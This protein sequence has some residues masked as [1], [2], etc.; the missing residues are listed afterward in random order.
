MIEVKALKLRLFLEGVEVPVIAADVNIQP[1]Q[2][3]QASIQLIATNS[4]LLFLPRTLVHLFYLD[5]KP[6]A[7]DIDPE[8]GA[9]LS[10]NTGFGR[11]N[12]LSD[13]RY[14]LLFAGEIVGFYYT[15]NSLNRSFVVQC[16]DFSSYWDSCYQWFADYSVNG[17]FADRSHHFVGSN[18]SIFNNVTT[19]VQ[20]GLGNILNSKPENPRYKDL[21]RG[22]LAGYIHLLESI[23]GIRP[24]NSSFTGFRGANDFFS[25]AELRYGLTAMLGAVATDK[26][27]A[28]LYR[29][30]AFQNWLRNGM[31]S[32]GSLV[33]FRDVLR[34]AGQYIFHEVYPNPAAFYKPAG[35]QL[36]TVIVPRSVKESSLGK[37]AN[38]LLSQARTSLTRLR[39]S[40]EQTGSST[41]KDN[42][43]KSTASALKEIISAREL[44][45]SSN[46]NDSQTTVVKLDQTLSNLRVAQV[47][48]RTNAVLS[49]KIVDLIV[50]SVKKAI[51]ILDQIID[52]AATV[53]QSK[54]TLNVPDSDFL[55]NQLLL[56]ETF[57]LSP[58]KCNVIFPDMY[59]SLKF[60]R[61]FTRE[62][63]RFALQS[64]FGA[65]Q[66]ES[67]I[68]LVGRYYFAPNIKDVKNKIARRSV[69]SSAGTLMPHEVH[70]GII[71]KLEWITEGHRWG[72]KSAKD[73]Q[74]TV[75]NVRISYIQRLANFQF[76]LHRWSSRSMSL[77]GRFM[78]QLVLGLPSVVID[79][80][81]PSPSALEAMAT[82]IGA[83]AS[84]LPTAFL[85]KISSIQHSINQSGGGTNVS[86]KFARTHRGLDDEFLGVVQREQ[87]QQTSD[88]IDVAFDTA[89]Q[90][91]LSGTTLSDLESSLIR[92]HFS[93][94]L[95]EQKRLDSSRTITKI[96][97]IQSEIQT[98]FSRNVARLLGI[99]DNSF[100][101]Y[102][103]RNGSTNQSTGQ[104]DAKV[105]NSIL[106]SITNNLAGGQFVTASGAAPAEVILKPG[107]YDVVWNSVKLGSDGNPESYPISENVYRPLLGTF[108]ITDDKILLSDFANLL[109]T[110]IKQAG[111]SKSI[112]IQTQADGSEV[113]KLGEVVIATFNVKE[114]T[115]ERAIDALTVLYG[116]L[117][118]KNASVTDFV[119]DYTQR[120]IASL[121]DIFGDVDLNFDALG[122]PVPRQDGSVPKVGFHTRAYGDYNTDMSF[123]SGE[124]Q[125]G[126]DAMKLLLPADAAT[127]DGYTKTIFDK[128]T[129]TKSPRIPSY[130]DPRGRARQ[131]VSVY[132]AELA[133]T[134]G[135]VGN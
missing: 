128:S 21:P 92:M 33:S 81:V 119:A 51:N 131:R 74:E 20:W 4:A 101:L 69:F 36:S 111:E 40:L 112:T 80:G 79:R 8:S 95:K 41:G 87:V 19:G 48:L 118:L 100:N 102:I 46:A 39:V 54:K 110:F 96:E 78:P 121:T 72:V 62:V 105:P 84:I 93:G 67:L 11:E 58:P 61:S 107:W 123:V 82:T 130:L 64:G 133:L 73:I 70:S 49:K 117:K 50:I 99:S 30:K 44:I 59:F 7:V 55:F 115:I 9:E 43:K 27:A 129:K 29:I 114:H 28:R 23:G 15:K 125:A 134:R 53:K 24:R 6:N 2:P 32:A 37:Q 13:S 12:G 56:P 103:K 124:P 75:R 17:N 90:R 25:I 66:D 126:K 45:S 57:F 77:S 76:F 31:A 10:S 120:P 85:G 14:K 34:L 5:S 97:I 91:L 88:V 26:T 38:K 68:K 86:F 71:P 22:L 89:E 113:V 127:L 94:E 42:V 106:V 16:L 35:N 108:A 109:Q 47:R 104:T 122:N 65:T 52:N 1:N 83:G 18:Q 60:S 135:L 3:A 63:S 98:T 132:A 116:M